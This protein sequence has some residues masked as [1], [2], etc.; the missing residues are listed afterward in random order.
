M[1][2]FFSIE[3]LKDNCNTQQKKEHKHKHKHKQIKCLTEFCSVL[4]PASVLSYA[5]T[6][7]LVRQSLRHTR[8]WLQSMV[9]MCRHS[10]IHR[11]FERNRAGRVDHTNNTRQG[12]PP[13]EGLDDALKANLLVN[14]HATA[15]E[16]AEEL[17]HSVSTIT[18][19][20]HSLG[21]HYFQFRWVPHPSHTTKK[22]PGQ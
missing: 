6:V 17:G 22:R 15:H 16:I 19:H 8:T 3:I 14:P 7:L 18:E 2:N 13:A 21:L 11:W 9:M 20:I 5:F 1:L 12:M 10:T 4:V